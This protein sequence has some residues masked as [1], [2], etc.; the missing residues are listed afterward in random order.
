MQEI[1]DLIARKELHGW[2]SSLYFA[3][4]NFSINGVDDVTKI[5]NIEINY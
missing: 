1:N 2:D 3:E 5:L 4:S